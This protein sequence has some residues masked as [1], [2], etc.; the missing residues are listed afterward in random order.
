MPIKTKSAKRAARAKKRKALTRTLAAKRTIGLNPVRLAGRIKVTADALEARQAIEIAT[1]G[2]AIQLYCRKTGAPVCQIHPSL[3]AAA[4]MAD[5]PGYSLSLWRSQF[6][7]PAWLDSDPLHLKALQ[8][9]MPHEFVVWAANEFFHEGPDADTRHWQLEL[10]KASPLPVVVE[11][12][13]LLRAGLAMFGNAIRHSKTQAMATM[14]DLLGCTQLPL[15]LIEMRGWLAETA[16][17]LI[18]S[19][20]TDINAEEPRTVGAAKQIASLAGRTHMSLARANKPDNDPAY[21]DLIAILGG[22][23]QVKHI[24]R[25][26]LKQDDAGK[27]HNIN[28]ATEKSAVSK[29]VPVFTGKVFTPSTQAGKPTKVKLF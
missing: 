7:H 4:E 2:K 3:M 12:A 27:Y 25:P 1:T 9:T 28:P 14:P 16:T 18:S 19:E 15:F 21:Q 5:T 11:L 17:N 22:I 29:S 26:K 23:D 10:I 24:T 20:I 13:E 8:R 6:C